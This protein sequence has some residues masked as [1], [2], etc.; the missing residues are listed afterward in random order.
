MSSLAPKGLR[1]EQEAG[2]K[3]KVE[4]RICSMDWLNRD[5]T[6]LHVAINTL[7]KSI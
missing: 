7:Y 3:G 5:A 2:A 6:I 1:L 4:Q